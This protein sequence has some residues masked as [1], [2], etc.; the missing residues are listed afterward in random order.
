MHGL[1]YTVSVLL[2]VLVSFFFQLFLQGASEEVKGEQWYLYLNFLI[3]QLCFCATAIF[4]ALAFG[5]KQG[6]SFGVSLKEAVRPKCK[7]K[8]FLI[9]VLLQ[10]GLFSLSGLNGFFLQWL[11]EFGYQQAETTLPDLN[12]INLLPAMIVIALFPALFEETL[13][14]GVMVGGMQKKGWSTAAIV[15]ISGALFSL[16][17]TSPA[18]TVYQFACGMCFALVAVRSGSA[19]PTMV[20]H[21]L[22]NAV[23][24]ILTSAGIADFGTGLFAIVFYSA[25]GFALAG[26]LVYLIF[27]DRNYR[28]N[29]GMVGGKWYFLGSIPGIVVCVL[30]WALVLFSGFATGG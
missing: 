22:N 5:K 14:R 13:F 6:V 18:Q 16:F 28:G 20:S 19:L 15:L 30:A 4:F 17:H 23:I 27:F 21:F 2:P 11:G 10:F 3:P 7:P 26:T 8:Y 12:G 24:L 25:S 29:K 1:V 9:A